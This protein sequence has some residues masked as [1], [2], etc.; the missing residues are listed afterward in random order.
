MKLRIARIV[1]GAGLACSMSACTSG[2]AQAEG[3]GPVNTGLNHLSVSQRPAANIAADLN[4]TLGADP[5][6]ERVRRQ[7]LDLEALLASGDLDTPERPIAAEPTTSPA[8]ATGR[9]TS[10]LGIGLASVDTEDEPLLATEG[11]IGEEPSASMGLSAFTD[12]APVQAAPTHEPPAPMAIVDR[13]PTAAPAPL[14]MTPAP[15]RRDPGQIAQEFDGLAARQGSQAFREALVELAEGL[16]TTGASVDSQTLAALSPSERQTI[17]ALDGLINEMRDSAGDPSAAEQAL[18]RAASTLRE[19]VGVRLPRAV[20]CTRVD[21]FGSYVPF[22][23]DTFLAGRNNPAL[24]YVEV[25]RF[26]HR[27]ATRRERASAGDTFAVDLT[28]EL[29][30][31]HKADGRLAWRMPAQRV[32]DTSGARRRDFYLVTRVDL[33]SNLTVGSYELKIIVTDETSHTRDETIIPI[34][35]V[36]DPSLVGR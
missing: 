27:E 11:N 8:P 5:L 16:H 6:D 26:I 18:T 4:E 33:P 24:V 23:H 28:Q 19:Q 12:D 35:I 3:K 21:G 1:C 36:A 20:L 25:D 29:Q 34:G 9:D 31:Y 14:E 32:V 2:G 17:D 10:G 30:L 15:A 13:T 22:E 7:A